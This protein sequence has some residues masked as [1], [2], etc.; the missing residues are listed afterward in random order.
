MPMPPYQIYC[1]TNGCK[2]LAHYKIAAEW[3]DGVVKE[4]KTYGLCCEECLAAWL[5]RGRERRKTCRLIPNETLE[6]PGIY[7][8]QRGERDH[9]LK[10]QTD[11]EERVFT[12]PTP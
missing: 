6:T 11:L 3:S 8:M 12:Q 1:Y 7:L 4:L 2:N 10:R 9:H 5:Q